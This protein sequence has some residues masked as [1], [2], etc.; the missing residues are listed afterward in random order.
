MTFDFLRRLKGE[1]ALVERAQAVERER[2]ARI[3]EAWG[4]STLAQ[5]LR[6]SCRIC[7]QL[8]YDSS[9]QLC[10]CQHE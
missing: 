2:C 6:N 3:A 9:G 5:F 4:H 8:G 7:H 1:A 10:A